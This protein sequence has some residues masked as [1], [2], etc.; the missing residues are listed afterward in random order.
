MIVFFFALSEPNATE[1]Q[2]QN[3][4]YIVAYLGEIGGEVPYTAYNARKSFIDGNPEIIKGFTNAIN[5]ALKYVS[6]HEA[7]D[8]ASS[9]ID[10]FPNTSYND[11]VTVV[12]AYKNG[13]AWR[14]DISI[15][16]DEWK[17]I[18]DIIIAA[19][20]LNDYA[21]YDDLIYTKYFKNNE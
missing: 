13:D 14:S 21:P 10:Y 12:D 20:E 19:G 7:S 1:L 6:E 8:I 15:H 11:L 17:H 3:L 9:I 16:S 4:G 2:K 5:R 18:Q